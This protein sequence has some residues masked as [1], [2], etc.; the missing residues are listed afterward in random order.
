MYRRSSRCLPA[1]TVRVTLSLLPPKKIQKQIS[2]KNGKSR[3]L[4]PSDFLPPTLF[5]HWCQFIGFGDLSRYRYNAT[6]AAGSE[7]EPNLVNIPRVQ[8]C[9]YRCVQRLKCQRQHTMLPQ[10]LNYKLRRLAHMTL[11]LMFYHNGCSAL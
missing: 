2:S 7:A 5:L 9:G 8:P 6:S 3:N 11:S 10:A 4:S 1:K